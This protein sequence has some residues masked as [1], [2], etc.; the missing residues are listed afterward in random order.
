MKTAGDII[1][2]KQREI[3]SISYDQTIR[4]ACQDML[5]KKIGAILVKKDDNYVGIWTERDLLRNITAPG[6]DLHSSCIGDFMTAP[7]HTVSHDT[8]LHKLEEMLLGLFVRH[9][10]VEKEGETIGLISIGDIL[11]AGLLAKDEQ[12]KECNAFVNWDYYENWK[13]GRKKG[14]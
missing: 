5:D 2:D 12:F 3:V 13:W 1:E 4:H 6:F 8:P 11:R 7:V 9:L 14:N 10:L